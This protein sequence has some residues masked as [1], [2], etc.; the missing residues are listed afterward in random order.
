MRRGSCLIAGFMGLVVVAGSCFAADDEPTGRSFLWQLRSQHRSVYLL[1]SIHFMKPGSSPFSQAVED[2]FERAGV[3]VFEADLGDLGAAAVGML[4][5]GSLADGTALD[6]VVPESLY[7]ELVKRLDALGMTAADVSS[8]KPWMVAL[9]LTSLELVRAGYLGDQGIDATLYE[10]AGTAGKERR[11]LETAEFQVSLFAGLSDE[12]SLEFLR[13]TLDELD[14]VIP[15]VDDIVE[16]WRAGDA[17]RLEALLK[18]GFDEHRDLYRRFVTDRNQAWLP[19][20]E[21]LLNGDADAIVVVGSLHLVGAEGLIAMLR[22]KG[23]R[24]TQL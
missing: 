4:S 18:E 17:D 24:V 20:I 3:V 6:Q 23:Y 22:A 16:A 13:Y 8:M 5:A 15:M 7:L 21:A 14:S 2:A 12:E 1:G 19:Q 10:R 9:S 11:G